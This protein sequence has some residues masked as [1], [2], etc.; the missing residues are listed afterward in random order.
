MNPNEPRKENLDEIR[1]YLQ[2]ALPKHPAVRSVGMAELEALL[3]LAEE[4]WCAKGEAAVN[5]QQPLPG[6][7]AKAYCC[8]FINGALAKRTA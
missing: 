3:E 8:G 2:L 1:R 5:W 7:V 4:S 6:L